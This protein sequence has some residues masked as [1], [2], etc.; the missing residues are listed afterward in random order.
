MA[1]ATTTAPRRPPAFMNKLIGVVLR[2]PLHGLVSKDLLLLTFTGRKSGAS[3]TTPVTYT[4]SGE[5]LL[6]FTGSPWWK[7]LRGGAP[8]TLR[9]RGRVVRATAEVSEDSATVLAETR[10]YLARKGVS[11]ARMI[12]LSLDSTREPT[13]AELRAAING[14]VAIYITTE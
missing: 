1:E 2:S 7:N 10:A 14:R 9:L 13:D 5:R 6:V 4:R 12:G 11:N 3:I 8:V